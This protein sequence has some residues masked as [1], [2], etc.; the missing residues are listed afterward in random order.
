MS[1]STSSDKVKR[2]GTLR[3]S[4][5]YSSFVALFMLLQGFPI[6]S[7][8]ETYSGEVGRDFYFVDGR[9]FHILMSAQSCATSL[10]HQPRYTSL[11]FQQLFP[12]TIPSVIKPMRTEKINRCVYQL[13]VFVS[14]GREME[15]RGHMKRRS[16]VIFLIVIIAITPL[17]S[18]S[19]LLFPTQLTFWFF[20]INIW[21]GCSS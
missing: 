18:S 4:S 13:S 8:T 17:I 1:N 2:W 11:Y 19:F 10:S 5:F 6:S 16:S 9:I 15:F 12:E 20:H 21:R 7:T 3:F 14:L